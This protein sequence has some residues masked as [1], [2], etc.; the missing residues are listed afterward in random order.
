MNLVNVPHEFEIEGS[1]A[2]GLVVECAAADTQQF[3]LTPNA[4]F[5]AAGINRLTLFNYRP[6]ALAFFWSHST[7]TVN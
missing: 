1:F 3:A 6:K 2:L 7:S 4:E 5:L